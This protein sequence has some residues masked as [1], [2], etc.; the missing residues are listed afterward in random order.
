[1][2][3]V[4][5]TF[6]SWN[7]QFYEADVINFI[8][9]IGKSELDV[10]LKSSSLLLF[11]HQTHCHQQHEKMLN[12]GRHVIELGTRNARVYHTKRLPTQMDCIYAKIN[13]S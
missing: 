11:H 7:L 5:D 8:L 6:I 4:L 10:H 9:Q 12:V 13:F 3:V 1:M 2:G